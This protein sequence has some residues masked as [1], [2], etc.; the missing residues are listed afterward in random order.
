M[1]TFHFHLQPQYKYELFHINFT[2][3]IILSLN[4]KFWY[5]LLPY[6]PSCFLKLSNINAMPSSSKKWNLITKLTRMCLVI[7]RSCLQW[8]KS[9]SVI[10]LLLL[11]GIKRQFRSFLYFTVRIDN[12][13][14]LKGGENLSW[15]LLWYISQILS[16]EG[17]SLYSF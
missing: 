4:A 3:N 12:S 5:I 17:V 7:L 1:I 11:F 15:V 14:K 2:E 6:C 10:Y 8:H 16:T 13:F 9:R